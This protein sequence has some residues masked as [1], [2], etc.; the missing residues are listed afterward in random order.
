M[1]PQL[2]QRIIPALIGICLLFTTGLV[3]QDSSNV[4]LIGKVDDLWQ[5]YGPVIIIGDLT[6][7]GMGDEIRIVDISDLPNLEIIGTFAPPDS[8]DFWSTVL[9]VSGNI[10]YAGFGRARSEES[11][12]IAVFDI[13]DPHNPEFV[14]A[15]LISEFGA[16]YIHFIDDNIYLSG[17]NYGYNRTLYYSPEIYVYGLEEIN[18]FQLAPV[19]LNMPSIGFTEDH[20]ITVVEQLNGNHESVWI[21]NLS[22]EGEQVHWGAEYYSKY[23]KPFGNY[24]LSI[25]E[26]ELHILDISNLPEF[27]VLMRIEQNRL[28]YDNEVFIIGNLAYIINGWG[29][30]VLDTSNPENPE[31]VSEYEFWVGADTHT[32]ISGDIGCVMGSKSGPNYF[33]L[34]NS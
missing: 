30:K 34:S 13:S 3:A 25:T 10:L 4:S 26:S 9:E 29:I 16:D 8:I 20:I 24:A 17:L 11:G 14:Q 32:D 15:I 33:D 28:G 19:T 6:Y 23:I 27:E 22:G 7:I 12:G 5:G 2:T 21:S 31:I 18:N 1:R